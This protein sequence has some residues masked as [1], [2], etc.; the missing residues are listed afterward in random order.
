M[1]HAYSIPSSSISSPLFQY[2][3]SLPTSK[4]MFAVFICSTI[5]MFIIVLTMVLCFIDCIQKKSK[6][7]HP[8]S[9]IKTNGINHHNSIPLT[10]G[11]YSLTKNFYDDHSSP[12]HYKSLKMKPVIVIA[13]SNS[14]SS[15]SIDSTTRANTA[16]NRAIA[17][18]YTYTALS[19]SD[20]LMPVDFDDD[21][22][23]A[24]DDN[25][26]ELMMTTV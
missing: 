13:S 7:N 16:L 23:E 15:S 25:G 6:Q 12:H 24:L 14:H 11:K 9:M 4:Q 1:A 26:I 18:T 8:I 17:N 5:L 3:S 10:N 21:L 20:D 2:S 19:T 22:N